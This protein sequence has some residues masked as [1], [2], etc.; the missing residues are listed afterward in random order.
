MRSLIFWNFIKILL[1]SLLVLG[2]CSQPPSNESS[3]QAAG[4][5]STDKNITTR[6]V[7]VLVGLGGSQRSNQRPL[8]SYQDVTEV[9]L[10]Y[11]DP[12]NV[13]TAVDMV[14]LNGIWSANIT[15]SAFGSYEFQAIARNSSGT[16]IF[17]SASPVSREVTAETIELELS[18]QMIAP[19]HPTDLLRPGCHHLYSAWSPALGIK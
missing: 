14:S 18:L 9:V 16:T 2:G 5:N 7:Q 11:N 12:D 13:T 1:I 3:R 8:G 4:N 19:N 6:T 10:S 17:E 15:L